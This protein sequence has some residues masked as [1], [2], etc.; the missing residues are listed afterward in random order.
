MA[1]NSLMSATAGEPVKD[2]LLQNS[3]F[4]NFADGTSIDFGQNSVFGNTTTVS[5]SNFSPKKAP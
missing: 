2:T 3:L 4:T 1:D 5:P